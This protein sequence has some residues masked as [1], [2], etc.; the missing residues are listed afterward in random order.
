M[1]EKQH[2]SHSAMEQRLYINGDLNA[3]LVLCFSSSEHSIGVKQVDL[4]H[5]RM[6]SLP[7]PTWSVLQAQKRNLKHCPLA[8]V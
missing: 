1:K 4:E 5:L 7:S 6:V 2:E 3:H 8:P